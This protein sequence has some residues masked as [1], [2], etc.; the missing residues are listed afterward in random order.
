MRAL[1]IIPLLLIFIN[2]QCQL[3]KIVYGPF[4]GHTSSNSIK[5]FLMIKKVDQISF[6]LKNKNIQHQ[7]TIQTKAFPEFG[8]NRAIKIEFAN[9]D[10]DSEYEL[11]LIVD[12]KQLK[13]TFTL[14]TL[15]DKEIAD[16]S[17]LLGSCAYIPPPFLKPIYPGN[18]EAIFK[19]MINT[20]SDF[21]IWLGDNVYYPLT[22]KKYKTMY[23]KHIK[24]RNIKNY[25]DFIQSRPNYAIWDDHDYGRNNSISDFELKD[26]ALH[27]HKNFW[28][29]PYYGE[30]D[31]PGT[32]SSFSLYDSEFLMLDCR[33][34]AD[35]KDSTLLGEKQFEWLINKIKS[36][37]AYFIFIINGI[38]FLTQDGHHES[39]TR[40]YPAEFDSLMHVIDEQKDKEI[41]LLTGDR[42][43]TELIADTLKSGKTIYEF[44]CSPLSSPVRPYYSAKEQKNPLLI[45]NSIVDEHNYGKINITGPE[46][47]RHCIIEVFNNK[48][49]LIW[50]YDLTE[51]KFIKTHEEP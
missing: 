19:H 22:L 15:S 4:A 27:I 42:H 18:E 35:P 29:N 30:N 3:S 24:Y 50:K 6:I 34:H 26:S 20:P 43:F 21:M 46:K 10:P 38:Q 9:L 48:G 37:K 13:K 28:A 31:N 16:F 32:Y 7:K 39:Y 25:H 51:H 17:F 44:T 45:K 47:N 8:K 5:L 1:F 12:K 36:S 41:V 40:S 14:K 33:Y 11:G 49:I 23:K 2:A